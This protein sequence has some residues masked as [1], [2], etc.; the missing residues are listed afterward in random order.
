ML[1]KENKWEHTVVDF[2]ATVLFSLFFFFRQFTGQFGIDGPF[3]KQQ[4]V[5]GKYFLQF[6]ICLYIYL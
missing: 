2:I 4:Y 5:V 3:D 6:N 1:N